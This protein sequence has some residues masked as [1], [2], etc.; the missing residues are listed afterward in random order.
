MLFFFLF[1]RHDFEVVEV[2]SPDAVAELVL[3]VGVCLD[4]L[5]E[6]KG[7][8]AHAPLLQGAVDQRVLV[9][10]LIFERIYS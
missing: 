2:A 10:L 4:Q 7:R 3:E 8:L 5:D 9:L 6:G 1:E